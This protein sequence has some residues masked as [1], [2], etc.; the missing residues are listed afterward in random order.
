MNEDWRRHRKKLS[1]VLIRGVQYALHSFFI[2]RGFFP[3]GFPGKVFNEATNNVYQKI[4]VLFFFHEVFSSKVLTK[5]TIYGH[6]RG[7][8]INPLN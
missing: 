4:C 1:D 6:P 3:L 2:D 5:H 7:S 8:V